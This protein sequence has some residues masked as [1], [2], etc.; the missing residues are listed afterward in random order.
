[1]FKN[2]WMACN[3]VCGYVTVQECVDI[4]LINESLKVLDPELFSHLLSKKLTAEIY[5]FPCTYV[6]QYVS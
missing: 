5:A 4:Q 6:S 1:M 2:H 3:L